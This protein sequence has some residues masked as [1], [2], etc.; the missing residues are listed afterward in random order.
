MTL[1]AVRF[2]L[3]MEPAGVRLPARLGPL[4]LA[5]GAPAWAWQGSQPALPI[6][7]F[8]PPDAKA[9]PAWG[10][11]H[12]VLTT[13][14]LDA[15]TDALVAAGADLR[16]HGT[17][18]KGNNAAFLLAGPLIEVIEVPGKDS[19]AI[20]G[21][22]LETDHPLEE[23]A[24]RWRDAGFEVADPHPAVQAGRLI[25]SIRGHRLAVMTRR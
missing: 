1:L 25:M 14:T 22:A 4:T 6:E 17:T 23:L 2:P 9:V 10:V 3:P 19:V 13:P 15:T 18:G 12:V 7:G 21:L 8:D 5:H 16:R 11:D 20:S 24:A